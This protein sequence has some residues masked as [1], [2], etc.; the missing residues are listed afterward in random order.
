MYKKTWPLV[1]VGVF[2]VPPVMAQTTA[3]ISGLVRDDTGA[4][5]PGASVTAKNVETGITRS[6]ST[7][8]QG[9]Y[10]LPSLSV[11]PYEVQ[12]SLSG[13]QTAV[14][15][16]IVLAVGEQTVANS[17]PVAAGRGGLPIC[18]RRLHS[19]WLH[20]QDIHPRSTARA[21]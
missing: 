6:V 17:G 13:F 2:L 8:E 7:D 11:G 5:I 1:L 9:R 19:E 18:G 4:V 3:T 21:E 16:G 10:Q 12:V 20:D 14:R 15:S